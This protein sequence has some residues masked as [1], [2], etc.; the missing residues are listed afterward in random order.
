[1]DDHRERLEQLFTALRHGVLH[2]QGT[3]GTPAV[4]G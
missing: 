4:S 2:D 1:V 3:Q